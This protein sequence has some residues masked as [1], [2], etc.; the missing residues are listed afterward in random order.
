MSLSDGSQSGLV[1]LEKTGNFEFLFPQGENEILDRISA[2]ESPAA[3]ED[4]WAIGVVLKDYAEGIIG[5]EETELEYEPRDAKRLGKDY[6]RSY[7]EL[8]GPLREMH[9]S[10]EEVAE[11]EEKIL[12][13][14]FS[15]MAQQNVALLGGFCVNRGEKPGQIF[16]AVFYTK[17]LSTCYS[18][19][20]REIGLRIEP[21][22]DF[23][24][25]ER[26]EE[27]MELL[28][29]AVN[30]EDVD[31]FSIA[32]GGIVASLLPHPATVSPSF[33]EGPKTIQ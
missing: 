15:N 33:G 17:I 13:N 28:R 5:Q 16:P 21:E 11:L 14:T 12:A 18:R 4:I 25:E 22:K 30:L 32:S 20:M 31:Q 10:E 27:N 24:E 6:R 26:T 23:P 2:G 1:E 9:A 3:G 19:V 7:K 29:R 8:V